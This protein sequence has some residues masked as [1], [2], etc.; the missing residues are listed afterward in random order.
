MSADRVSCRIAA[1]RAPGY[2]VYQDACC[3][4]FLDVSPFKPGHTLVV[5][6][7]L[8]GSLS[9]RPTLVRTYSRSRCEL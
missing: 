5:P 3:T 7:E 6:N 4:A 2:Y 8:R 9:C 1:K